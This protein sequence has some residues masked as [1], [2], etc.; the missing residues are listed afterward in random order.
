MRIMTGLRMRLGDSL[1]TLLSVWEGLD[2]ET[3]RVLEPHTLWL[4]WA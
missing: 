1:S 3:I 4:A 2:I